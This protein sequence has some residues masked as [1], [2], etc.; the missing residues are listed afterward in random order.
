M[1]QRTR[2]G[3]V[4]TDLNSKNGTYVNGQRTPQALLR[5]GE[6]LRMGQTELAF[7]S[8]RA[9]RTT[10]PSPHAQTGHSA[11]LVVLA[12]DQEYAR[13]PVAPGTVLGRYE[14]CPVDLRSDALAS[15]RHAQLDYQN[16]QWIIT[17]LSSDN[18]TFVNGY[19]VQ[20]Q[21]LQHG[22]EIR[23]GNTRMQFSIT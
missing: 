12:G 4:L 13:C 5:G 7:V 22:D 3:Y 11:Q 6:R 19:P 9:G 23:L 2:Y 20:S 18:Q 15:R 21:A 14:G 10:R 8:G 16:G 1:I 17:D